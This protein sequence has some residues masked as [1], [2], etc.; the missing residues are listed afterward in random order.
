MKAFLT[1][2]EKGQKVTKCLLKRIIAQYEI[3]VSIGSYNGPAFVA[4]VVQLMAKRLK[5]QKATHGLL[6]P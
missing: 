6:P 3:P 4:K 1:Q 5:T 2:I